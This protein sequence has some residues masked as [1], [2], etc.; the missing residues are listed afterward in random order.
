MKLV[1]T[2]TLTLSLLGSIYSTQASATN[3]EALN[4]ICENIAADDKSRFRKKL[5]ESGLKLR[6]I[7]D[8]ISCGGDNLVRYAMSQNASKVGAFIV[9]RLPATHF[10]ASGDVEWA[11]S[12][13]HAASPI[14]ETIAAR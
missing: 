12:N 7:Y 10:S 14:V 11:K 9:K 13:G 3:V 4:G 2:L 5:K 6:N 8:S 1:A